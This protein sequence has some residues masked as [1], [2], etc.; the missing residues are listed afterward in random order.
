LNRT[1]ALFGRMVGLHRSGYDAAKPNFVSY[2]ILISAYVR[3]AS[4]DRMAAEKAEATLLEMCRKY[5]AGQQDCKPNN[6]IVAT[7]IDGWHRSGRRDAGERAEALLDWALKTYRE[8]RENA[9]MRPNEFTFSATISAWGRSRK[10]GKAMQARKILD[11]MID[12]YESGQIDAAPNTHCYTAV[13]NTCAHCVNDALEMQNAVRIAIS[14]YK[15]LTKSDYGKANEVTYAAMITALRNLLPAGEARSSAVEKIF[16]SAASSGY[17]DDA[18]LRC[19]QSS[20][21][22]EETWE[23]FSATNAVSKDGAL[24]FDRLPNEWRRNVSPNAH[25]PK[26]YTAT[27]VD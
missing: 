23:L 24:E 4:T 17:V 26:S 14:T 7:V 27:L 25:R 6:Q 22:R 19:V 10:F 2:V 3:R 11:R 20:L 18:V 5:K 8:E 9:M 21:S 15:D 13:I 12:L 1:E 16:K